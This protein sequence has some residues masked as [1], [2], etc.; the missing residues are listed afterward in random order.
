[1]GISFD[2]FE[3]NSGI[4]IR[5]PQPPF[6]LLDIGQ[7]NVYDCDQ[8]RLRHYLEGRGVSINEDWL[9]DFSRNSGFDE[10]GRRVNKAFLADFCAKIGIEYKALD[11]FDGQG[12]IPFDLNHEVLPERLCENFDLVINMGTTEHVLNQLNAFKVIH[13]ATKPG[14]EMV[15]N[16]PI[17]GHTNHCYVCYTSRFF[18]DLAGN[19]DYEMLQL[20][21]ALG[22]KSMLFDPLRN[23]PAFPI[24]E[25]VQSRGILIGRDRFGP[26]MEL[27]DI[28]LFVR[29][30][31]KRSSRF[32]AALDTAT[33]IAPV[34]HEI[35]DYYSRNSYTANH[36]ASN[37][38]HYGS[39]ELSGV[40][41]RD[42]LNEV[43]RRIRRRVG[44]VLGRSPSS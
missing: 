25:T 22:T 3:D 37:N 33:S 29:F 1:M 44:M 42:L 6:K 8:A 23:Y 9:I 5:L 16:L 18:F 4:E 17:S 15:H 43:G 41:G 2:T 24:L 26:D 21:Y 27:A 10:W 39:M 36:V 31:K 40:P 30:R 35:L 7:S 20:V 14:G 19:N 38:V 12:V 34:K 32:A 11:I 13:D 28:G